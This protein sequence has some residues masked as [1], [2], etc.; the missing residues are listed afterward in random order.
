M[1]ER[2]Q[3][4]ITDPAYGPYGVGRREDGMVVLVRQAVPGDVVLAEVVSRRKKMAEACVVEILE[5]SPDRCAARCPVQAECG[6]CSWMVMRREAQ[7][8]HKRTVV[9]RTLRK[10][11]GDRDAEAAVAPVRHDEHAFGYR[12]RARLHVAGEAGASLRIGFFSHGT[13]D[14]VPISGCP[15]CLPA[16]D[17]CIG[18]LAAFRPHEA[19]NG[20]MEFIVDDAERVLAIFYLARP[21]SDP[22]GLAQ[23]LVEGTEL[24]GCTVVSPKTGRAHWGIE[25]GVIT[26]QEEPRCTIPVFPGAFSQA[27]R[28]LNR[29]LVAHAVERLVAGVPS[30]DLL[31]LYAGHGNFT[32]PLASHGFS[33]QAVETGVRTEL[34][35]P[36]PTVRFARQDAGA[37]LRRLVRRGER[38]GAVLLDPPRWGAK[39]V[40]PHIVSLAPETVLY[41]SCDPNT[42]ARDAATLQAGGYR[43]AEVVPFDLMPQTFHT[44]LAGLFLRR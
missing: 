19:V 11:T 43:L 18:T 31:E 3:I 24:A 1:S 32:F 21:C 17:R 44:E 26:V 22:R 42:F 4:R 13:H 8:A 29:G 5:P 20:S 6:G 9:A 36:A 28:T 30:R 7:L 25:D 14:I 12:Q 37:F 16:L 39:E 23:A 2:F 15:I 35:P 27:N 40:V 10:L 34:L 33:V 38:V 41:V